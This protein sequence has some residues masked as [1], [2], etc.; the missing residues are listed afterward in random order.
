MR[1]FNGMTLLEICQKEMGAQILK[2]LTSD[3]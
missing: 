3:N 1:L 2:R